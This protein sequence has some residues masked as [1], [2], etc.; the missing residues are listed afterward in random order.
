MVLIRLALV[1]YALCFVVIAIMQED[2]INHV[3]LV[4]ILLGGQHGLFFAAKNPLESEIIPNQ[5]R[6]RFM[7]IMM[8]VNSIISILFPLAFGGILTYQ[9]YY[10]V[11][12]AVAFF[13]LI[14]LLFA[15]RIKSPSLNPG[16]KTRLV[17]FCREMRKPE[18]KPIRLICIAYFFGG[19]TVTGGSMA[20]ILTI[21]SYQVFDTNMILG[22]ATSAFTVCSIISGIIISKFV[23]ERNRNWFLIIAFVLL[24]SAILVMTFY[25]NIVTIITFSVVNAFCLGVITSLVFAQFL[26]YTNHE[27]IKD[28]YRIEF[29][30]IK[31]MWLALGRILGFAIMIVAGVFFSYLILQIILVVLVASLFVFVLLSCLS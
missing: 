6:V 21:I 20:A 4:G 22:I 23:T 12:I 30:V 28:N 24:A 27:K 31:E 16:G 10:H 19:L 5:I 2:I 8:I 15:C 1:L 29:F 3:W 17:E 9:A 18:N 14:A 26:N 7:G 25:T 11:S 13:V